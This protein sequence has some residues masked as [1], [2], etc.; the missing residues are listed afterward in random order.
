[1]IDEKDFDVVYNG[2]S[3]YKLN[4]HL[5][6]KQNCFENLQKIKDAHVEKLAIYNK[7][8]NTSNI[9][10]LKELANLITEIEFK[11]Q[12][13]WKFPKNYKFHRFWETPKCMCPK[14]DNEDAYPHGYY[15]ISA[16]CPLHGAN[17]NT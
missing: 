7:I 3:V 14:I 1:M 11:L 13:L 5:L 9:K 12:E 10:E 17:E 6:K 8:E 16:D 15:I 4:K 2:M